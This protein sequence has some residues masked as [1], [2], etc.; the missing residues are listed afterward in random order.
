MTSVKGSLSLSGLGCELTTSELLEES[1]CREKSP[2]PPLL[3]F[4]FLPI[5]SL[6]NRLLDRLLQCHVFFTFPIKAV[7][8]LFHPQEPHG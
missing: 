3:Y 1:P 4:S 8:C 2:L 7:S 5:T 6:K